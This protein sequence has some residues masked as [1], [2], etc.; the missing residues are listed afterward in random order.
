MKKI[1]LKG[2]DWYVWSRNDLQPRNSSPKVDPFIGKIMNGK[3]KLNELGQVSE[4]CWIEI[5]NHFPNANLDEFV[6]MPNHV[7]GIIVLHDT[8]GE[9]HAVPLRYGD[10]SKNI[11]QFGNLFPVQFRRSFVHSNPPSHILSTYFANLP[12]PV[13]QRDYYEHIIRNETA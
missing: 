9:R 2:W 1:D 4:T 6:I 11:E 12:A 7:H 8:V 5:T 10:R 13:W 3:M